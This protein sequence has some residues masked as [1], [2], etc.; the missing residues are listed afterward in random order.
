[1]QPT[2]ILAIRLRS[3]NSRTFLSREGRKAILLAVKAIYHSVNADI[4]LVRLA[5]F[6]A[7]WVKRCSAIRQIRR[8]PWDQVGEH[9]G[10]GKTELLVCI[11]FIASGRSRGGK[12][13][14]V[15]CIAAQCTART[16]TERFIAD[17]D[18]RIQLGLQHY[19]CDSGGDLCR[20]G[21]TAM[22]PSTPITKA[23]ATPN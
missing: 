21:T 3:R 12:F 17:F 5:E 15:D 9:R 8:N 14:A 6:E 19:V 18:Q 11:R 13:A 2:D 20:S 1:M 22:N 16:V 7:E 23:N 4:A 10:R